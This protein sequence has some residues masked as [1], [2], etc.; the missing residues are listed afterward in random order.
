MEMRARTVARSAEVIDTLT[1]EGS[2]AARATCAAGA[3]SRSDAAKLR[4][5]VAER[6]RGE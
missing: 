2:R 5:S 6:N 3:W 1:L 4:G